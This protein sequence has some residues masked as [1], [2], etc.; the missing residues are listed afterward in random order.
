MEKRI[1]EI[2]NKKGVKVEKTK[3]NRK[4]NGKNE[5]RK[6]EKWEM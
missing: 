2:E 6:K 5:M 3:E 1:K 4:E